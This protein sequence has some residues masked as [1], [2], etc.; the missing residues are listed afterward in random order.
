MRKLTNMSNTP[1]SDK[2][3]LFASRRACLL[4][5]ELN[6]VYVEPAATGAVPAKKK[7]SKPPLAVM[8]SIAIN[9]AW[10]S[11]VGAASLR[12]EKSEVWKFELPSQYAISNCA[13]EVSVNRNI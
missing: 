11:I 9:C 12:P 5:N 8:A 13:N 1:L 4:M 10:L 7:S 3:S 2:L 6:C